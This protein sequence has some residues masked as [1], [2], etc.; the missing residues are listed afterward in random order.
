MSEKQSDDRPEQASQDSDQPNQEIQELRELE[1][2]PFGERTIGYVKR[3]GPGLLQSAMT[4]GAGSAAASVIAGASFGYKLLWVQPVAMFLGV[5]ML[6]ALSNVVLTTGERP[7]K[8]FGREIGKWLVVLWALGTIMSSII[9]HFPQYGLAAAAARDLG[10]LGNVVSVPQEVLDANKSLADAKETEDEAEIANA[11][12]SL[13]EIKKDTTPLGLGFTAA[14]LGISFG[15]GLL[16]LCTN[17]TTV[18]NY[19]GD[20]K[21]VRMYEW[22][23]RS[24]IAL[25]VVMFGIV[26]VAKINVVIG[27]SGE[28]LKGFI[29]WYGIPN[30]FTADGSLNGTTVTQVLGMLGAAVGINMTFLYPYSLLKKGWGKDHKKLAR[31]DLGMTMFLPFVLVTSLVIIAMK[32]GGVYQGADVVD[33]TIR[34]LGAAKAL[35]GVIGENAGRVI[36]DLGLIGMTCGA[37]STHMVVCGFTFCEMLGLEQTKTRFRIFALAPAIGLLGVIASLPIWFPVAASAV[38]FTMLPIAYLTFLIMN[39]KRSYIGDAVGHGIGRLVF[40]TLLVIA[41]LVATIGSLIQINNRV[42]KNESV[43][44]IFGITSASADPADE[45]PSDEPEKE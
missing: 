43:R 8:S 33:T 25:V 22:F 36:F 10:A 13:T 41:L 20:S 35:G 2:K 23:L 42:I 12:A 32:V 45:K 34:P 39:N 14:G 6:G 15:I 11:K 30:L 18:F 17:I 19:G 4:L 44:E 16:I 27:E 7:Y 24:C 28:I 26:V 31:W 40:N 37:I 21:G 3:T 38:C 5:M 29:G 1:N 9:W